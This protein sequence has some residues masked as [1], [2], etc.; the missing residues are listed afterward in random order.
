MGNKSETF[1]SAS[2]RGDEKRGKLRGQ[3]SEVKGEAKRQGTRDKCKRT[4][5]KITIE[6]RRL[7]VQHK[8]CTVT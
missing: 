6:S 7:V 8:Y 2:S 1:L 4:R 5:D 3:R